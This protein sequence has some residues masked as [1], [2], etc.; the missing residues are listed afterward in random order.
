MS[1]LLVF[2]RDVAEAGTIDASAASW[3]ALTCHLEQWTSASA[4]KGQTQRKTLDPFGPTIAM[5]A[6]RRGCRWSH[7]MKHAGLSEPLKR[8]RLKS[9]S[10]RTSRLSMKA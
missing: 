10:L 1:V 5:L 6:M 2:V 7:C 9:D 3:R 4:G 8:K